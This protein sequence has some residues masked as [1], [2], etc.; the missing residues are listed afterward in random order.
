MVTEA[1][2]RSKTRVNLRATRA[3]ETKSQQMT[4]EDYPAQLTN[5]CRERVVDL[6]VEHSE[7][8]EMNR[9]TPIAHRSTCAKIR[10][11]KRRP[12]Q[13]QT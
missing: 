1:N 6:H 8:L 3:E 11:C 9:T 13:E 12:N 2:S 5:V 4:K 7:S 10:D